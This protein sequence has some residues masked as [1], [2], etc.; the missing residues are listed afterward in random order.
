MNESFKTVAIA[1]FAASVMLVG[2]W[3]VG[4]NQPV[5]VTV[6]MPEDIKVSGLTN[7][8]E[9]GTTEGYEVDNT[10]VIDGSG[11]YVGAFDGTTATF[12]GVVTMEAESNKM[13]SINTYNPL[14]FGAGDGCMALL[15]AASGTLTT[16]ATSTSFCSS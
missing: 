8:D 11:N 3:L 2:G 9:M 5:N 7:F 12:S 10:Q 4:G 15:A 13:G 16:T 14:Y 1:F 6:V